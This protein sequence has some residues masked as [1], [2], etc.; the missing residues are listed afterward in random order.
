MAQTSDQSPSHR[1]TPAAGTRPRR[2][3]PL[4]HLRLDLPAVL[5]P[6]EGN[7][8]NL[9]FPSFRPRSV[10]PPAFQLYLDPLDDVGAVVDDA[11]FPHLFPNPVADRSMHTSPV[12]GAYQLAHG[13]L[14]AVEC[15]LLT[16]RRIIVVESAL[17]GELLHAAIAAL[18]QGEHRRLAPAL[19]KVV[20]NPQSFTAQSTNDV[21]HL[22]VHDRGDLSSPAT[23]TMRASAAHATPWHD[24]PEFFT[25]EAHDAAVEAARTLG[26]FAAENARMMHAEL[27]A[28]GE[29]ETVL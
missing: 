20:V 12:A 23:A 5:V 16:Q 24:R 22:F 29:H 13:A 7:R 10:S 17:T 19:P 1:A 25:G 28:T 15:A 21:T 18:K 6:G 3:S 14:S 11:E 4:D 9:Y 8:P 27:V 2:P 26:R